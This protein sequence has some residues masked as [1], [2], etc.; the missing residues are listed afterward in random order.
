MRQ[1]W[2]SLRYG[3]V[4]HI[5]AMSYVTYLV[6]L[7][8]AMRVYSCKYSTGVRR[9][10]DKCAGSQLPVFYRKIYGVL[11]TVQKRKHEVTKVVSF[12]QKF[13]RTAGK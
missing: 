2:V 8:P 9:I 4:A 7:Y 11:L 5:P 12:V 1:G 6:L 10:Y 13:G 3:E